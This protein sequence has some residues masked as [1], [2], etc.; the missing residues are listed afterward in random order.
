M[1]SL[2]AMVAGPVVGS[3]AATLSFSETLTGSAIGGGGWGCLKG[4]HICPHGTT[5]ENV[6]VQRGS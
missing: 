2:A 3:S 6:T 1:V 4:H 5:D